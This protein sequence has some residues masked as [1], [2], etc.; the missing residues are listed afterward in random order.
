MSVKAAIA[1]MRRRCSF[2]VLWAACLVTGVLTTAV[3]A[4]KGIAAEGAASG[5]VLGWRPFST[6]DGRAKVSSLLG[7]FPRSPNDVWAVG[8]QGGYPTK[9]RQRTL[10][11]HWNGTR[12]R[13]VPSPNVAAKDNELSAVTAISRND[14]WA[15]G[16]SG[17]GLLARA[18]IQHWNGRNWSV[19][20][21]PRVGSAGEELYGVAGTKSNDVWAVGQYGARALIEHWDGT[22]WSMVASPEL[23]SSGL[24]AVAA[25]S[26][27]D[28]WAVGWAV[29]SSKS[30]PLIEHWDGTGWKVVPGVDL[31]S[32]SSLSAVSA[33]S[34]DD[35]W[36][37]GGL[38][39]EPL[40][41]HW[42]GERWTIKRIPRSHWQE[43]NAFLYG[44]AA[45]ARNDVWAT[46]FRLEH[47]DGQ[48]WHA[49]SSRIGGNAI[50]ALS[51]RDVWDVGG[52]RIRHYGCK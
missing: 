25:R 26:R 36:A 42:D 3:S 34:A 37:V 44:V 8:T 22:K 23:D 32:E 1:L 10:I 20:R 7:V 33:I 38:T 9:S 15:V 39:N 24:S 30:N 29:G 46:G 45:I 47:W 35:V 49:G 5:C 17:Q 28:V 19:V 16:S 6:A 40:V 27:T 31:S 2:N 21:A 4:G 13:L 52:K 18:L 41:E 12:W 50:G 43:T 14:A 11:E 48:S 51:K